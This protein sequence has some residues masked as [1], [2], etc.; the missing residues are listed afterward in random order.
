M[1]ILLL[2]FAGPFGGSS[3][4]LYEML[5]NLMLESK[6]DLELYF[7]TPKG[8]SER[9]FRE[10]GEV[11]AVKGLPQFDHGQYSYYRGVR[12]LVLLREVFYVPLLMVAAIKLRAKV[13]R[14]DVIHVNDFVGIFSGLFFQC[15]L[16]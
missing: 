8:T 15:S 3:R 12:W 11:V 5:K 14:V 9:Y 4:S 1:K 10:L 2:H 13:G 7:V 6:K 16:Y